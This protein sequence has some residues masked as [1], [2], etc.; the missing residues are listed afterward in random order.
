[1]KLKSYDHVS[2]KG[3]VE[4]LPLT[5]FTKER[6]GSINGGERKERNVMNVF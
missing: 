2:P 4:L 6:K 5:D 1:V 3:T